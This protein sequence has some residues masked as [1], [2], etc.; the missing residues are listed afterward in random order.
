MNCYIL[1]NDI[2]PSWGL[3]RTIYCSHVQ[4]VLYSNPAD[5]STHKNGNRISRLYASAKSLYDALPLLCQLHSRVL[6]GNGRKRDSSGSVLKPDTTCWYVSGKVDSGGKK[7]ILCWMT[8][9]A[10]PHSHTPSSLSPSLSPSLPRLWHIAHGQRF[11]ESL[12]Q[13]DTLSLQVTMSVTHTCLAQV[14]GMSDFRST[15]R[16][17]Q[18]DYSSKAPWKRRNWGSRAGLWTVHYG[19]NS[20]IV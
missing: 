14:L 15:K 13:T 5:A 1:Q 4:L 8:F 18:I 3:W 20:E 11:H 10:S 6:W 2:N 17:P 12:A 16:L 19:G 9:S 7:T